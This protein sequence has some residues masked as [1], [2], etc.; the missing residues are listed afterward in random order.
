MLEIY[1]CFYDI[2]TCIYTAFTYKNRQ[3]IHP[4]KSMTIHAPGC[5]MPL[6][7][8]YSGLADIY[9][10]STIVYKLYL[11]AYTT[12]F[13]YIKQTLYANR[14][15]IPHNLQSYIVYTL[16][17]LIYTMHLRLYISYKTDTLHIHWIYI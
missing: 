14:E 13:T 15:A 8:I 10:A 1:K 17:F 9:N 2:Y 5:L 6:H 16:D 12:A 7:C 4:K 11:L 3:Y